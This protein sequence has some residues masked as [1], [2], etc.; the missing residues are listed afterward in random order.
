MFYMLPEGSDPNQIVAGTAFLQQ[1][2]AQWETNPFNNKLTLTLQTS[3][4]NTLTNSF[5][6][7]ETYT[8]TTNNPFTAYTS[9]PI[10]L[11]LYVNFITEVYDARYLYNAPI[12]LMGN[13][14]F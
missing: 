9:E 8:P 4:F 3:N 12:S 6:T 1:Y 14:G 5:I 10:S 13:M 2:V 7:T 11:D